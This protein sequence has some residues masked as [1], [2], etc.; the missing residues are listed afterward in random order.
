MEVNVGFE[1][2]GLDAYPEVKVKGRFPTK[3]HLQVKGPRHD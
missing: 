1:I 3:K 2:K